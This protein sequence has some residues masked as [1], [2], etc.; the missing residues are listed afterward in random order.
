MVID[1]TTNW[2]PYM[3]PKK[4][5]HAI[6]LY[7]RRLFFK[8]EIG[9]SNI[10]ITRAC[11][12]NSP[13]LKSIP[14]SCQL[15][16]DLSVFQSTFFHSKLRFM[17]YNHSLLE[18]THVHSIIKCMVYNRA[19]FLTY[20]DVSRSSCL[21]TYEWFL[22]DILS[23]SSFLLYQLLYGIYVSRVRGTSHIFPVLLLFSVVPQH[24][25]TVNE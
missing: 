1:S 15:A 16:L 23:V 10:Q 20:S 21:L 17:V 2:A 22:T 8:S 12:L 7:K 3:S 13:L 6:I 25:P 11:R 4:W 24:T 9:L 14:C 18:P 5:V 19:A